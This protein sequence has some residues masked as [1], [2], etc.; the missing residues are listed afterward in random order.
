MQC[1]VIGCDR[2]RYPRISR[3]KVYLRPYC[4]MHYRRHVRTKI[5][6]PAE[7][8]YQGLPSL[9]QSGYLRVSVG[10]NK[11][12]WLHRVIYEQAHG[13]IPP[14]HHVHHINGRKD[15][16]RLENLQLLSASEHQRLHHSH[17]QSVGAV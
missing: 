11:Q 8:Y 1:P 14:K 17:S 4:C 3:G 9:D 13:A 6:G 10:D 16:N 5:L 15:D 2:P 12:K 7:T